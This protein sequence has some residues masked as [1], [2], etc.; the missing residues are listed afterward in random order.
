MN[1]SLPL[2]DIHLPDSDALLPGIALWWPPAPGWWL[3][4][5][6][7]V[8]AGLIAWHRRRSKGQRSQRQ[9]A[10]RELERIENRFGQQQD[11]EQQVLANLSV[12]LRRIAVNR[13]PRE[14]VA[15]LTGKRWLQFLDSV[16]GMD[17]FSKGAG[18]A[19]AEAPYNPALAADIPELLNVCRRWLE[20]EFSRKRTATPAANIKGRTAA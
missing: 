16:T 7:L 11:N 1:G 8:I 13:Y 20:A 9:L 3:L 19:L 6:L 2:R 17:D 5:A 18:C 12:L 14:H 15:S 10:L 4:L